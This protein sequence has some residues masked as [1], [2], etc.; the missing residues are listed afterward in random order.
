MEKHFP[1]I[2]SFLDCCFN[3][4]FIYRKRIEYIQN[5]AGA[6]KSA[7]TWCSNYSRYMHTEILVRSVQLYHLFYLTSWDILKLPYLGNSMSNSV[8]MY[9]IGTIYARK[10]GR[11]LLST[12]CYIHMNCKT[13]NYKNFL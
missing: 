5:T 8:C 2:F 7:H 3:H 12:K 9:Y 13:E 6:V 4:T 10:K 11:Q 1:T